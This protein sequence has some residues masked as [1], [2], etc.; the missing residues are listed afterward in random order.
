M[1]GSIRPRGDTFTALWS[2]IDPA[3]GKRR[4]HSR[5]GF[6]TKGAAQKHLNTVLPQVDAGTWRADARVT[7]SQLLTEH[8]LP[9]KRAEGLRPSTASLYR[10][11]IETWIVPQIGGLEARQLT[12]AVV[13]KM[14]DRLREGGSRTGGRL[15]AR[16]VQ[17]AV[18][19]LK[20]ATSWAA[21]NDLLGRDP[22]IA[23]RRP[24]VSAPVM[25]SWSAEEARA[26]LDA[27]SGDRLGALWALLVTRGLRRGEL[28]GIQWDDVD[29]DGA[30][31][32]IVRT[33]VLVDGRPEESLPKTAAGRRAIPLDPM[34]V[35]RLRRHRA[36]QAA[37]KLAAGSAYQDGGGWLVAD[38]L[39]QPYYPDSISGV[40]DKRV[41]ALGLR[42]IRFHD[43]RHTAATLMLGDGVS[44]KTVADLLGHDPRITLATYT[45]AVP[46][47]GEAAGAALSSRLL[48]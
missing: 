3:T 48:G 37:E 36:T 26:F 6:R 18:G 5:G 1:K 43:T 4:Q 13:G 19:T 42:R 29:L 30:T 22:L 39:G 23:Y 34:L 40:F 32:R 28:C 15:S 7:V 8:W 27:T 9:A 41:K 25:K 12:P 16:S 47:L 2:T 10:R 24:K 17:I 14:A 21:R 20:S 31:I 33:R 45:H 35:A 44:V 38:E 11:A 46:G